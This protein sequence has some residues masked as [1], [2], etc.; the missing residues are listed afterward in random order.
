MRIL[1]SLWESEF[2]KVCDVI[3]GNFGECMLRSFR[4]LRGQAV[5]FDTGVRPDA[6]PGLA[7]HGTDTAALLGQ[8]VVLNDEPRRQGKAVSL[9]LVCMLQNFGLTDLQGSLCVSGVPS[10]STLAGL[11][12][13]QLEA[14]TRLVGVAPFG[15]GHAVAVR[16]IA[17]HLRSTPGLE[18]PVPTC[19]RISPSSYS[20]ENARARQR[21]RTRH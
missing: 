9:G 18:P 16:D 4:D 7:Y 5:A 20:P 2:E 10:L 19:A 17:A 15:P 3:G 12:R 8:F 14:V 11:C 21:H 1:G 6:P 13:D